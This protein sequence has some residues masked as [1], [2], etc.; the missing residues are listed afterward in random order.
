MR[1]PVRAVLAV[2]LAVL[3]AVG[4]SASAPGQGVAVSS[5]PMASDAEVQALRERVAAFWAARVA[6]DLE[7]Q[8]QL[9][10]P[11]LKN[12]MT[13]AE[14]GADLT[15]GRWLAY[16]VE[17]AAVN[18]FFATVKVRLLVK[19]ILPADAPGRSVRGTPAAAV[20]NDH[21]IR[22]RGRWYRT[23]DEGVPA[24]SQTGQP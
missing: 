22:I 13:A 6:G 2:G 19:P 21:W 17:D 15:G 1:R 7:A 4:C 10:E 12:R 23:L 16:K 9:L 14:Y 5:A 8:W 3:G 20:L 24:P 11:R 18:G